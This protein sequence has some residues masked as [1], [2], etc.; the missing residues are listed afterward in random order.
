MII[1]L[2][3]L[4]ILLLILQAS[5]TQVE[6]VIGSDGVA[7]V[8]MNV[9]LEE[10]L[11]AVK[12]PVEPIVGTIEVIMNNRTLIPIYE[13]KTLYI[14]APIAG[15]AYIT[16][17]ANMTIADS[18]L[19]LSIKENVL[20]KLVLNPNVIP[21]TLPL[22]I[23]NTYY[24]NENLVIEFY[25]PQDIE[26][27]VRETPLSLIT[28]PVPT[29]TTVTPSPTTTPTTTTITSPSPTT[30]PM[31][32]PPL[33]TPSYTPT[34]TTSLPTYTTTSMQ[35]PA[36]ATS[37]P[38]PSPTQTPTLVTTPSPTPI[39][40]PTIS[41]TTPS[42]I[43]KTTQAQPSTLISSYIAPLIVVVIVLGAIILVFIRRRGSTTTVS[44]TLSNIDKEILR[45]LD[46]HSGSAFQ[47]EL[48]RELG[49]PKTTL[50]RHVKKLEKLGY[51]KIVKEDGFNRIIL[52][53][54]P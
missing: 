29:N 22:N 34:L 27:V 48:Q 47:S 15:S 21:L 18:I 50:W 53:R 1:V 13:N 52:V 11:N 24:Y 19:R 38:S 54:K 40:T 16:Y 31:T 26:Y 12:L 14:F 35:T 42:P 44:Y 33:T 30:S 25:G 20:V 3:M 43:T 45:K 51:V 23:V 41:P 32:S 49:I 4:L 37:T 36:T 46:E 6:I 39:T 28:T 5:V 7:I 17:V 9:S 2:Y 8:N 10:G